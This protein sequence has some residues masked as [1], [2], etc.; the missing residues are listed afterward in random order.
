MSKKQIRNIFRLEVFERDN[1]TCVMC[2]YKPQDVSELDAHHIVSRKDMPF[3]GYS[4]YNGIS[5]CTDRCPLHQGKST[6]SD[7]CDLPHRDCHYKAELFN[8][9]GIS[10]LNYSP[11]EL[12]VKI[13]SSLKKA[14][15]ESLKLDLNNVDSQAIINRISILEKKEM[16]LFDKT[17]CETWELICDG[18]EH[19]VR[20][21]GKARQSIQ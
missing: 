10:F 20:Q 2:G 14:Y 5:L 11:I 7:Y 1:Q 13:R 8:S 21:Y 17:N 9:T 12:Y 16:Q 19:F 18:E 15:E 4:L 6:C 3:G